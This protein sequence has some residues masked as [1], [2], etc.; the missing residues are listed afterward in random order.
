MDVAGR[1]KGRPEKRQQEVAE[2][3]ASPSAPVNGLKPLSERFI[4]YKPY[5]R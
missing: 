3:K 5:L 4:E 1:L 2:W